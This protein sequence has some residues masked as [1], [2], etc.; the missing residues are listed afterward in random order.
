AAAQSR[1]AMTA[2]SVNLV[3]EDDAWRI[4]L[5]LL[6]QVAYPAGAHAHEHFDKVRA[7]NR[8]EGHVG[9]ASHRARQQS[10]AGSWGADEQHAFGDASAELLKFLRLA[11][12]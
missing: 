9:F 8:K 4:L 10:L 12:E 5:T 1:A 6:E 3:D 2:D 7:G 11:Q